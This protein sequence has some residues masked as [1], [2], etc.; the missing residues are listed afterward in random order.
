[1]SVT[2]PTLVFSVQARTASLSRTVI[3][4]MAAA[5][6]PENLRAADVEDFVRQRRTIR[7][8]PRHHDRADRMGEHVDHQGAV[9]ALVCVRRRVAAALKRSQQALDAGGELRFGV[10]GLAGRVAAE[11]CDVAAVGAAVAVLLRDV[12]LDELGGGVTSGRTR[13]RRARPC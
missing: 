4:S 5:S 11:G 3:S 10:R 6:C 2:V 9:G 12:G 7:A 8:S 1:M 13:I